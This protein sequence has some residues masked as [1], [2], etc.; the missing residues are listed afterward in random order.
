MNAPPLEHCRDRIAGVLTCYD[1]VVVTGTLP[2]AYHAAG[3][4]NFLNMNPI[5]TLNYARFA[6]PLRGRIRANAEELAALAGVRIQY[7][8]K[9]HIRKKSI[10]AEIIKARGDH[11]GLVHIISGMEACS[12]HKSWFDKRTRQTLLR[13]MPGKCRHY[14]FYFIDPK[15][16]LIYLRVTTLC[17]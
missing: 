17:P 11:P 2:G 13:P 10:V 3:I 8:A 7:I 12:S 1:R 14:Y 9:A 5:R 4:T 6:E 16:G 15:Q